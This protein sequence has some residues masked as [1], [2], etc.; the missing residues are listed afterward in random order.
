MILKNRL[1][2]NK[3]FFYLTMSSILNGWVLVCK[4]NVVSSIL[5][6]DSLYGGVAELVNAPDWKSGDVGSIPTASTFYK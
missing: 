1:F 3:R 5:T 6:L 4:T 2:S